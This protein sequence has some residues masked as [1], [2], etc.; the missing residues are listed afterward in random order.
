MSRK[1]KT[2][3]KT[4]NYIE[5]FLILSSRITGCFP[6]SAFASLLHIPIGI[7]NSAIGLK[8][9]AITAGIKNYNSIIKKK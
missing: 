1:H 9:C 4:L 8:V 5:H 3:C 2:V 7:T 6:I